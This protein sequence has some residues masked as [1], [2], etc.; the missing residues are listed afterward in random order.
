MILKQRVHFYAAETF[1]IAGFVFEYFELIAVVPVEA[2]PGTKP[3]ESLCVLNN[4]L[5]SNVRE[6]L[7][8]GQLLE[9]DVSAF[10]YRQAND[11]RRGRQSLLGATAIR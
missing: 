1:G 2:I 6:I 10:D 9:A 3:H 7:R 4:R 5:N 8:I 11:T